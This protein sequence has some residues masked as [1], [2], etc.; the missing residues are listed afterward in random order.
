MWSR[1]HCAKSPD[2]D[3]FKEMVDIKNRTEECV[4]SKNN[5]ER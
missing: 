3:V 5:M 4:A 1:Q 2:F